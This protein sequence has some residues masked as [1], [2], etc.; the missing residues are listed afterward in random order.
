MG[1]CLCEPL[2][3][4]FGNHMTDG[5]ALLPAPSAELLNQGPGQIDCEDSSRLGYRS[6]SKIASGLQQIAIS[7]ASGDAAPT[8]ESSQ[9]GFGRLLLLQHPNR[10][11]DS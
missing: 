1:G 8:D 6:Q 9:N 7:L 10:H 3:Q 2:L 11:I 4:H 5:A